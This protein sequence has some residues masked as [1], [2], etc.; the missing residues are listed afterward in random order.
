V[1]PIKEG[2]FAKLLRG[3]T[4]LNVITASSSPSPAKPIESIVQ[5]FDEFVR[6]MTSQ[7][8]GAEED[9]WRVRLSKDVSDLTNQC[10]PQ[11]MSRLATE[12]TEM[13]QK[14]ISRFSKNLLQLAVSQLK[15]KPSGY[16]LANIVAAILKGE[17]HPS[18][19]AFS[20]PLRKLFTEHL[21]GMSAT[22]AAEKGEVGRLFALLVALHKELH[23]ALE[24]A[25]KRMALEKAAKRMAL[26]EAADREDVEVA[27]KRHALLPI[28]DL[29]KSP[30]VFS[31]GD[32][33]KRALKEYLKVRGKGATPAVE[34]AFD[35]LIE[36]IDLGQKPI[37]EP[38]VERF[39][40]LFVFLHVDFYFIYLPLPSLSFPFL[41]YHFPS[42]GC[43]RGTLVMEDFIA[44][45]SDWRS[46]ATRSVLM[47]L[48]A[49]V[50]PS[51]S[52]LI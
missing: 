3:V 32:A 42:L 12:T 15:P 10:L 16:V 22:E 30:M 14:N 25:A 6:T 24:E 40:R 43:S 45:G 21:D 18:D 29:S 37:V 33:I 52:N 27:A 51:T 11:L 1:K 9:D 36:G 17:S 49:T 26:E 48:S 38:L 28:H 2:E 7:W 44:S 20:E 4:K 8:P 50:I 46:R 41:S 19:A 39:G 34:A 23:D 13:L 31:K 35:A 47:G 5:T